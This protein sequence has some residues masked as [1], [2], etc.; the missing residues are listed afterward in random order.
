[1]LS[2]RWNLCIGFWKFNYFFPLYKMLFSSKRAK[3]E[4]LLLVKKWWEKL[5][6]SN[7]TGL[8]YKVF[9]EFLYQLYAVLLLFGI[10]LQN[11]K[12]RFPNISNAFGGNK[13][14][15]FFN[16]EKKIDYMRIISIELTH[17]IVLSTLAAVSTLLFLFS[18]QRR[19]GGF[20]GS[21]FSQKL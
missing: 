21:F 16:R 18:R 4:F 8:Y 19:N 9:F 2:I 17:F 20:T 15:S 13:V 5:N 3:I 14:D 12:K 7:N 6:I 1:M 10:R 11:T